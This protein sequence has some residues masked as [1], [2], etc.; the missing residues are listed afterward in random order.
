MIVSMRIRMEGFI[1]FDYEK[2][3]PKARKE[4]TQWL[5]EGKLQ[6][7]ETVV[8]GGLKKAEGALAELYNGMNTG[9]LVEPRLRSDTDTNRQTASRDQAREPPRLTV[10]V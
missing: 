3:Y 7:K 2:D 8:K 4:L 6:R 1:V 10:K 5:S 9:M